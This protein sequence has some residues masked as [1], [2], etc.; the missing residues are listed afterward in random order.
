MIFERHDPIAFP[1]GQCAAGAEIVLDV[2]DD[3]GVQVSSSWN[4]FPG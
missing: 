3:Q 1:Y 4:K 2:G